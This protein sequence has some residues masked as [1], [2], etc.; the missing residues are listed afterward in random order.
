LKVTKIGIIKN[1]SSGKIITS[2]CEIADSFFS[3]LKG[4]MLSSSRKDL[5]LVFPKEGRLSSSIHMLFMNYPLDVL[6]INEKMKI[7]DVK[8]KIPPVNFLKR[9]TWKIYKPKEKAKYILELRIG[10]IE[11]SESKVGDEV[12]F[13]IKNQH[14]GL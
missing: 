2:K 4:L 8:K 1:K 14:K 7:V 6:W 11:K 5:L 9:K 13:L 10:K 12:E 3:R